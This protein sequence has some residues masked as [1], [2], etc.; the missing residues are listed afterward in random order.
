M[1]NKIQGY[2]DKTVTLLV[3]IYRHGCLQFRQLKHAFQ[4][5][6]WLWPCL[7]NWPY[8]SLYN[9]KNLICR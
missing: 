1:M 4:S 8:I 5:E 9:Y 7:W 3:F 2:K 6:T